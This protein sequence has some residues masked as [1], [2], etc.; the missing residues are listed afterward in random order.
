MRSPHGSSQDPSASSNSSSSSANGNSTSSSSGSSSKLGHGPTDSRLGR[1]L[2]LTAIRSN[3]KQQ[4][5]PSWYTRTQDPDDLP[6]PAEAPRRTSSYSSS[7]VVTSDARNEWHLPWDDGS[8]DT[9]KEY[10]RKFRRAVFS[11]DRWAAHRSTGRYLRHFKVT[12]D[13]RWVELCCSVL[14]HAVVT[15]AH[16]HLQHAQHKAAGTHAYSSVACVMQRHSTPAHIPLPFHRLLTGCALPLPPPSSAGSPQ[17]ILSSRTFKGLLPPLQ[18]LAAM[19]LIACLYQGPGV[20]QYHLPAI[21]F[22]E[23]PLDVTAFALSLLLVFRTDSSYA[24]WEE[25]LRTWNEVRS[26]SKDVARQVRQKVTPRVTQKVTQKV[27]KAPFA[28]AATGS[29]S[30]R[31]TDI[32]TS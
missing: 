23:A 12:G 21:H 10:E 18:F 26:A 19:S 11:F 27:T 29:S 4:S 28:P 6:V 20:A 9:A 31:N 8:S 14:P 1:L 3:K 32:S 15:T 30:C 17:G 5:L 2:R 16:P 25:A 24:R 22:G 13:T 7:S